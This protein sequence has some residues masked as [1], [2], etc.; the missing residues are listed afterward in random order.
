LFSKI[1]A[2]LS[3]PDEFIGDSMWYEDFIAQKEG[4]L[5]EDYKYYRNSIMF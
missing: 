5:N 2:Y 4:F 1:D 3:D